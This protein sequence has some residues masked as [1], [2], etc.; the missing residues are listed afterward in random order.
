M[1]DGKGNGGGGDSGADDMSGGDSGAD[2]MGGGDN[3]PQPESMPESMP[4]SS[5]SG[6]C[7][8]ERQPVCAGDQMNGECFLRQRSLFRVSISVWNTVENLA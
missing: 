3:M 4:E 2:N 6:D 8:G 5:P 7:G 1:G